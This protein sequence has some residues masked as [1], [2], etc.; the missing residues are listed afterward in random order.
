[1]AEHPTDGR[2]TNATLP[3]LSEHYRSDDEIVIVGGGASGLASAFFLIEA[4]HDP[5]KIS[6]HERNHYLGGNARSVYLHAISE[7]ELYVIQDYEMEF[8][9]GYEDIYLRYL[10]HNDSEQRVR[11][12][13]NPS[14]I[15][16]DLG[17]CGISHRYFNY[18]H[19]LK[20]LDERVGM[21]VSTY[22]YESKVSRSIVLDGMT[23]WTGPSSS[24]MGW[25]Q[26]KA[27]GQLF[28]PWN[29]LRLARLA[30]DVGSIDE[31]C[32][33]K[34]LGY[35][36]QRTV[37]QLKDELRAIS[38]SEDAIAILCSFC[39]V[40]SGY[41][42]TKFEEISAAY[43]YKFFDQGDFAEGGMENSIFLHGTSA[44]IYKFASYLESQGV[45][46]RKNS[47]GPTSP[48][49]A[50]H[51][52][53]A[54]QPYDAASIHVGLP[55]I[56][57]TD[58]LAYL[59]CNH[60]LVENR[61][62]SILGYGDINGVVQAYWDLDRMRPNHPN[63]GAYISFTIPD[64]EAKVD[65]RLFGSESIQYFR[66]ISGNGHNLRQAPLKKVWKHSF[67]DVAAEQARLD[68]QQYHQGQDGAFYCGSSYLYCMLHENAVT[69]AL[70]V[71]CLLTGEQARLAALGF[72][73]SDF[74][75]DIHGSSAS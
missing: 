46:I 65:E 49:S 16:V 64:C 18:L 40:G 25:L 43:C 9:N 51:T 33:Q 15:P 73:P 57:K 67:I 23:L 68:I 32:K 62:E 72:A 74:S 60:A 3:R 52:I 61:L 14:L 38:V 8:E 53:Y 35:L 47:K 42:N 71:A 70:D 69:S 31:Y 26:N 48:A 10:D 17:V 30:R 45:R 29:W 5:S 54:I 56:E 1:M 55:K 28:H 59:H 37:A 7:S 12:D 36:R 2:N 75:L 11:V 34:G 39:Q 6:I 27:K 44:Y 41:G 24:V 20:T 66:N 63:V 58:S 22:R 4:G 50:K 21:G 19:L 13:G